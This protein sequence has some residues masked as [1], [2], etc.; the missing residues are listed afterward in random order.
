MKDRNK[1]DEVMTALSPDRT[2]GRPESISWQDYR[3]AAL[4][5]WNELLASDPEERLVHQFLELHPA[6]IP[7]GIGDVGPGGHHGSRFQLVFSE[8]TLQGE[9]PTFRPDFMWITKSSG[10]ITPILIEIEK[11]SKKWFRRDGRP[12][13]NFSEAHDQLNDWRAWFAKSTN[14]EIFRRTFSPVAPKLM[15]LPLVPQYLLIYGRSSEFEIG[16]PH[17]DPHTLLRKRDSQR[18]PDESF[19]SFDSLSPAYNLSEAITAK[20]T[21]KGIRMHAFSPTFGTY[22]DLSNGGLS[23]G[24]PSK[25]LQRTVMMSDDR[26]AYLANRWDYWMTVARTRVKHPDRTYSTTMEIE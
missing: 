25:A 14:Q 26:K 10:L 20:L 8:P 1:I 11:P 24:G 22:A 6:F 3:D 5:E 18:T 19:R 13:S 21:P 23:L 12:T 15:T 9:G 7:G 2:D 4:K 16:G 17:Q